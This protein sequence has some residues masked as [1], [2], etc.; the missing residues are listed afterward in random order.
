M[1]FIMKSEKPS[2]SKKKKDATTLGFFLS[3]SNSSFHSPFFID[4]P[5]VLP[6]NR[7]VNRN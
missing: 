2:R 5:V 6:F 1:K 3:E 7:A 4:D